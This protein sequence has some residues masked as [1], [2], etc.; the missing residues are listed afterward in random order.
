MFALCGISQAVMG[1]SD[2][3][4]I[5][6]VPSIAKIEPPFVAVAQTA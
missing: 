1:W 2:N 6:R 4:T 5:G 3:M